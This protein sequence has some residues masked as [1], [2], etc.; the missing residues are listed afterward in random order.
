MAILHELDAFPAL[1][2]PPSKAKINWGREIQRALPGRSVEVL[3]GTRG[4]DR[5][6][7]SD[8]TIMNYEIIEAWA[9]H[10]PPI[11]GVVAD[12]SHNIMNPNARRTKAVQALMARVPDGGAAICMTGTPSLNH[13]IDFIPQLKAIG[14]LDDLGGEDAFRALSRK[15]PVAAHRLLR[16]TC[17]VR[18]TKE[19]VFPNGPA[20]AFEPLFVEGDPKIMAE[21]KRA[22]ADIIAYLAAKARAAAEAAGASSAEADTEA[23]KATL[24]AGSAEQLIAFNHLRQLSGAAKMAAAEEWSKDF[25]RSGRKLGIFGWHKT[26]VDG[27][28]KRLNAPKIQGG[29]SDTESQRSVDMFQQD[30]ATKAIALQLKAAGVAITLTAASDALFVEQGWNPGTMDQALDRF[31]R[32]GQTRDVMG[33]VMMIPGTI[34]EDMDQ[35]IREKRRQVDAIT[36]GR[37]PE[38]TGGSVLADLVV[39]YAQRGLQARNGSE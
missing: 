27:I 21:Y 8:V 18:R 34:D 9:G 5:L 32:R 22:E 3:R 19:A 29:Q 1:V 31:H 26:V 33:R 24:M 25:L 12:E 36:D 30:P 4:Q 23:W 38:E 35:I 13:T 16:G 14:R 15:D 20:R 28:A 2:I 7:W 10:L 11:R 6:M 37:D 17:Y 39:R